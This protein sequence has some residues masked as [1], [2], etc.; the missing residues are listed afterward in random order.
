MQARAV[1]VLKL[2]IVDRDS[3]QPVAVR[4]VMIGPRGRE[5]PIRRATDAGVGWAIDGQVDLEVPSGN[6]QFI[7]IRGP[8]YRV[9]TGNFTIDRTA[10]DSHTV[11]LERFVDTQAENWLSGDLMV[12]RR[13]AICRF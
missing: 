11:S 3:K 8:E 6:Y 5:V 9:M 2:H 7:L 10:E 12:D 1:G 13:L 4:V